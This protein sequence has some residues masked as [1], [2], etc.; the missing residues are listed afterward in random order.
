M[1]V[2]VVSVLVT[3]GRACCMCLSDMVVHVVSVLVIYGRAC[4]MCLSDIWSC[5]LYVS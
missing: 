3:Y 4:C 1:V 2:H 5:M